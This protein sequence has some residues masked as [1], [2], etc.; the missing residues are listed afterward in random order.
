MPTDPL[1]HRQRMVF[2]ALTIL[3]ALT[4]FIPL[5]LGP[6]DW[7]EVLFCLAVGDYNVA[8]HQP[9][10]AGFPLFV[11]L[12]KIARRFTDTD[13]H[14]LQTVNVLVSICLFPVMFAAARAFRLDFL[15]SIGAALIFSFLTNVWF[16]GGTAFSDPIGAL[17]FLAAIAAYLSA[18]TDARRYGLASV[19]MAAG[20]LV[21]PQ[22]AIVAVFPWTLATVRKLRARRFRTVVAGSLLLLVLVGIGYGAAA[23]VTG[24]DRYVNALRGHSE[25]VKHAD[26]IANLSRPS[27]LD[28]LRMQLDPFEGGKV[29]LLINILA[30]VGIV[31]GRRKVALE[32]LG[33]FLP[34]FLFTAIA[35]NPGGVSRF[36]LNWLAGVVILAVEGTDAL[37][38]LSA[39]IKPSREAL[40]RN[41]A[42]ASLVIVVL[43]RLIPWGLPAFKTPRTTLAPPTAAA[44]WMRD[45][46]PLTATLFVDHSMYPWV[47]YF[48]PRHRRVHVS[49][50][51]QA[52]THPA[53]A[54][55]W[56][57]ALAPPP[58]EGK[59]IGFI[60]PR[61]RIYNI[62]TKRGFEAFV[63]S[64]REM[65]AFGPGW[66]NLEDDG[67]NTWHWSTGHAVL[68]LGANGDER[69]LS[70]RFHVPLE[71]YT[72]PVRVSFTLNG[73]PLGSIV[74]QSENEVRYRIRG[75]GRSVNR[76][77][78]DVSDSFVPARRGQS[79]DE[80]ELGVM[81]QA[82]SWRGVAP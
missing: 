24:F 71:M 10:P 40:V 66:H 51:A 54:D 29:I 64:T 43:A 32:V 16:Y 4:R 3:T 7:D 36:S 14:A 34:F 49:S 25:Y 19:L 57:V 65:V 52:L 39:R 76:V 13:F 26:T 56:Y 45:H 44:L 60:R 1:T 70:L 2:L 68:L 77:W 35:A 37:A 69:E 41:A 9:H 31:A 72:H 28:V 62:V 22:N 33:T 48:A 42:H 80:R 75:D 15:R 59:A 6:W 21:R 63:Q 20:V 50:M 78:M 47:T 12:G 5:S 23:Y 61:D 17:A 67:T 74:A 73:K 46:V 81:L 53:A 30:L 79:G 58:K 82:W 11:L 55:G 38:R 18:G 27:L 8:A